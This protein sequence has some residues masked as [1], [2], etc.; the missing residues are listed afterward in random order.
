MFGIHAPES[1]RLWYVFRKRWFADIPQR[2]GGEGV[3]PKGQIRFTP[4][5]LSFD[6]EVLFEFG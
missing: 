5:V 6:G 2:G 3:I 4:V 1:E